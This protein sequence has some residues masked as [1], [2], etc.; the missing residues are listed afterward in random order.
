MDRAHL[1]PIL[2]AG[3][4][5][6]FVVVVAAEVAAGLLALAFVVSIIR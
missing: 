1:E 3:Y 6:L 2:A 4:L 5:A